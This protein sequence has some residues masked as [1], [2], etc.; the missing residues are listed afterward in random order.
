MK[1]KRKDE[2]LIAL[3]CFREKFIYVYIYCI[4]CH[5][6]I[7]VREWVF[8]IIAICNVVIVE[9]HVE[10]PT[11]LYVHPTLLNLFQVFSRMCYKIWIFLFVGHGASLL[12]AESHMCKR[13]TPFSCL[14]K[15]CKPKGNLLVC[16]WNIYLYTNESTDIHCYGLNVWV[17]FRILSLKLN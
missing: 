10:I 9:D 11:G 5:I 4:N 8:M 13:V 2:S 14:F 1:G 17:Y 6:I 12:L 3:N 7:L 15:S 16:P